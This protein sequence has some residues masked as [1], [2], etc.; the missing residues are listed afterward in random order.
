MNTG[1]KRLTLLFLVL[2]SSLAHS[3]S[4]QSPVEK[5]IDDVNILEAQT[6]RFPKARFIKHVDQGDDIDIVEEL[7][8]DIGILFNE[9]NKAKAN[10][11]QAQDFLAKV[12]K[13]K[14]DVQN[15]QQQLDADEND[16]DDDTASTI[17]SHD[18]GDH[19]ENPPADEDVSETNPTPEQ[20]P[21][22]SWLE[23][24]KTKLI[25]GSMFTGV[26]SSGALLTALLIRRAYKNNQK[27]HESSQGMQES[28]ALTAPEEGLQPA[29]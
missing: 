3:M 17:S 21:E 22:K 26:L 27:S 20:A 11:S 28:L 14:A 8:N 16:T 18:D 7:K 24:N 10:P 4:Q 15:I 25:L 29:T 5:A 1:V 19:N 9:S 23:Q 13:A 6:S 2:G 12:E